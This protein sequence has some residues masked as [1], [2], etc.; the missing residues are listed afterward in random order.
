MGMLRQTN[1]SRNPSYLVPC[2]FKT[3]QMIEAL[4]RTRTGL[5]VENLRGM[6]GY[7]RTT[8]YRI[9]RTLVACGYILRDSGGSY[10]L[11]CSVVAPA[12]GNMRTGSNVVETPGQPQ[13]DE[14][15][16]G[17][18]RWG[19]RFS[20]NGRATQDHRQGRE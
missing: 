12:N 10:R 9:L 8:I 11:N 1:L 15:H 20:A 3:V 7:S 19:V 17:F 14:T 18:E 2:V 13:H 4:R 16:S 6:T 5:R